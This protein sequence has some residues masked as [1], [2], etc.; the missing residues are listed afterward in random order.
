M[1]FNASSLIIRC[2][3]ST[4]PDFYNIRIPRF[5][6]GGWKKLATYLDR[7]ICYNWEDTLLADRILKFASLCFW[8]KQNKLWFKTSLTIVHSSTQCQMCLHRTSSRSP[9]KISNNFRYRE[10]QK[11]PKLVIGELEIRRRRMIEASSRTSSIDVKYNLALS[12]F[13]TCVGSARK[14]RFQNTF[15]VPS[16][17]WVGRSQRCPEWIHIFPVTHRLF[18]DQRLLFLLMRFWMRLH[19][20]MGGEE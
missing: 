14:I 20:K 1:R 4:R 6:L 15:I 10:Q 5:I 19:Y 18:S 3:E 16:E 2:A 9:R 17:G 12:L 13:R 11:N 8:C 7:T